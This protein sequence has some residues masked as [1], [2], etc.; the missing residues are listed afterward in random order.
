M[1]RRLDKEL[2]GAGPT[3]PGAASVSSYRAGNFREAPPVIFG[4]DFVT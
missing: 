2:R 4:L 3:R 1:S